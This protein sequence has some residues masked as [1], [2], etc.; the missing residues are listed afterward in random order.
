MRTGC[1]I[2]QGEIKNARGVSCSTKVM[3][4]ST[5]FES[6]PHSKTTSHRRAQIHRTLFKILKLEIVQIRSRE[7]VSVNRQVPPRF[8]QKAQLRNKFQLKEGTKG[9][10]FQYFSHRPSQSFLEF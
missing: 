1:G 9:R 8:L 4:K 10:T 5:E 2:V 6:K 3:L 7:V